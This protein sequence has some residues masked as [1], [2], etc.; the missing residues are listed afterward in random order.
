[1][2]WFTQSEAG[3]DMAPNTE[4]TLSATVKDHKEYNGV[5]QTYLSRCIIKER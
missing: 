3:L 4:I 5:K 1:M 2:I